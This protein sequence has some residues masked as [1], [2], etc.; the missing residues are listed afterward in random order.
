MSIRR[1]WYQSNERIILALLIKNTTNVK[2]N[3]SKES[4]TVAGL[5]KGTISNRK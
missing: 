2:C 1:D 4:F 5:D 3:L